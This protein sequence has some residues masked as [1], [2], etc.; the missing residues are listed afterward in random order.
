MIQKLPSLLV[1]LLFICACKKNDFP[2][3]LELR[4]NMRSFVIG[5]SEYGKSINN[6]FIIIPQNGIELVTATGDI[7]SEISSIYLN[8]IDGHGQEDLFYGYHQDDQ[9]SPSEETQYLREFLD[10]S[11]SAGNQILVT[12]YCSSPNKMD[13]AFNLCTANNYISFAASYRE[14]DNIPSYPQNIRNENSAVIKQLSDAQN[15]LYLINLSNFATKIDFIN[16]VSNT[17]YDIIITD[18]FFNDGSSFTS[19]EIASLKSKANGGTRLVICYLSIGEAEDY[20]YYWQNEWSIQ[21]TD[22]LEKENPDWQGNYKVQYWNPEWQKIIY[23]NDNSYLKKILD[24]SF[25]GVYLDIIDAYEYF[26]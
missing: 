18:L 15:F 7:S 5:I 4:N 19:T 11:L 8:A 21:T 3:S 12:D 9:Q 6:N 25:D 26:E 20:R 17:N 1:C 24:A 2:S 16:T 10:L 23:G 13:E 14:L 22:W